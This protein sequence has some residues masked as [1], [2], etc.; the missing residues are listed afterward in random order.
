MD[1]AVRRIQ[2]NSAVLDAER[3]RQL[4]VCPTTRPEGD[5]L[6][7][8]RP[9]LLTS[10]TC[11]KALVR[12]CQRAGPRSYLRD[13]QTHV[14]EGDV[15]AGRRDKGSAAGDQKHLFLGIPYKFCAADHACASICKGYGF[16]FTYSGSRQIAVDIAALEQLCNET[17]TSINLPSRSGRADAAAFDDDDEV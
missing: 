9:E 3:V 8:D 4:R 2:L 17:Q 14:Q 1:E 16:A 5:A 11:C 6:T 10:A 7:G 13:L 12:Q 15:R